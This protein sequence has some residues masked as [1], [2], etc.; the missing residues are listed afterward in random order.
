[1]DEICIDASIAVRWIVPNQRWQQKA[2]RLLNDAVDADIQFIAPPLFEYEMESVVQ[3]YLYTGTLL[4][5]Q[6]DAALARL[7]ALNIEIVTHPDMIVRARQ[8]AR[9]YDQERIYD[10]LYAALA[11]LRGCEF[12]TADTRFY[13]A[14]H[15]ELSYVK[16]L[17]DYP[18]TP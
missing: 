12:W 9:R 18:D 14:V 10:S 7:A 2:R 17:Q 15:S 8:I 4:S 16:H 5:P 3:K 13:D 1:M 11:E 6:A